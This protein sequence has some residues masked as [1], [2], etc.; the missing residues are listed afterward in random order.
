MIRAMQIALIRMYLYE[1]IDCSSNKCF[2]SRA[3]SMD[4]GMMTIQE[5]FDND[6]SSNMTA[7]KLLNELQRV[8]EDLNLKEKEIRRANEL[9]DNMDREIHELT[10]SLFQVKK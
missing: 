7:E 4:S 1:I 6:F 9:R 8:K 5:V 2:H 3:F 10:A